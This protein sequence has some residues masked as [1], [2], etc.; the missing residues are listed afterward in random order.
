[1]TNRLYKLMRN[2]HDALAARCGSLC[3]QQRWLKSSLLACAA[4]LSET[5]LDK[6]EDA[7]LDSFYQLLTAAHFRLLSP[8]D[9]AT[10]QADAFTAR[11][12]PAPT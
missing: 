1:M 8:E 2:Y 6:R 9:W 4:E 11:A 7:S 5:E 12:S 3:C 10:A